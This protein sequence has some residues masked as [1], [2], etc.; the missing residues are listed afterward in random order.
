MERYTGAPL[1]QACR[2]GFS[3]G[4]LCLYQH[5]IQ[6]IIKRNN[7][8]TST[9]PH[10]A[11]SASLRQQR[12]QFLLLLYFLL[13]AAGF[14]LIAYIIPR[15]HST[16]LFITWSA[17]FA[18]YAFILSKKFTPKQITTLLIAA[19]VFRTIFIV[20]TPALS[21]DF[22]RYL[23]D[24]RLFAHGINPF[25]YLPNEALHLKNAAEM[26]LTQSL[27]IK[28]NS[29]FYYAVYPPVMQWIFWLSVKFTDNQLVS[30]AIMRLFFLA[31]EA[32]TI[33]LS[34]KIFERWNIPRQRILLYALNPLIIIELTGNLHFEGIMAFFLVLTIYSWSRGRGGWAAVAFSLA[35]CT[36]LIPLMLLPL[37]W[38]YVGF[39]RFFKF[40]CIVL[41]CCVLLFLPFISQQFIGNISSS[42]GLYFQ[43]FEFNASVYYLLREAGYLL[44]GY[45]AIAF[46]GKILPVVFVLFI[47]IYSLLYKPKSKIGLLHHSL[48]AMTVYYAL[49]LVVH[50]WYLTPLILLTLFSPMRFPLFWSFLIGFTYVTY[51]T[52][53]YAENLWV[54]AGEYLFLLAFM[55]AGRHV[56]STLN[57]K[58]IE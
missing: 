8:G 24:G 25:V 47:I 53:P 13:S 2:Q 21:D 11:F 52:F 9:Q 39:K 38:K 7:D 31:A 50:P 56:R 44:N 43:R 27:F 22:Y 40:G 26:G 17:L 49:S 33:F 4:C 18:A 10:V 3:A 58:E 45:N 32:G 1:A 42:V 12:K 30:L 6:R 14:F 55:I 34:L 5:S 28:L 35:V 23:W 36:K 19:F 57:R 20:A 37:L 51:T 41:A 16:H 54:V 15:F 29:P 46:L 48:L